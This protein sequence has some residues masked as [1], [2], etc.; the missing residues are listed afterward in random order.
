ML[1]RRFAG[2]SV[3]ALWLAACASSD[4][5]K[6][7]EMSGSR[8][9]NREA[10]AAITPAQALQRLKEGNDRFVTGRSMDR[11]LSREV[12]ESA[13]GQFPFAAIV[14]CVDSRVAPELVFDQGLGDVFCA[15][16]AGNI[17]NDDILGS[18]EFATKGSGAKLILV[19]GHSAC[20]AVKGAVGKVELGHLTGLL[21]R[22]DPA[23]QSVRTRGGGGADEKNAA[24]VD[25]VA[26]ENVRRMVRLLTETSPILSDLA[27]NGALKIVGGF[28]DLSSGRVLILE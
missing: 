17:V 10:Q 8:V 14:G 18:L 12:H 9:L 25:E 24:F 16:V 7:Q 27:A 1:N 11:D 15:R 13:G 5:G 2:I 28:Q 21:G 20:G 4:P 23:V 6:T 19:V 3:V 26:K 22:I